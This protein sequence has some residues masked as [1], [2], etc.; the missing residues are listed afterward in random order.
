MP[1]WV[2]NKVSFTGG[3]AVLMKLRNFMKTENS[4]FDF[5]K[6]IP[7]PESLNISDGSE[8]TIARACAMARRRG[9]TTCPEVE[10]EWAKSRSFDEWAD[11]GEIY[12]KNI[13]KYG[14]PTWYDWRCTHWGTKWNAHEPWWSDDNTELQ[15]ETAWSMPEP[16]FAELSRRYPGIKIHIDFADEDLGNNCGTW[17]LPDEDAPMYDG[18]LEFA[19]NVWDYDYEEILKEREEYDADTEQGSQW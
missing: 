2:M 4:E 10:K 19:C 17:D 12:L 6:L 14:A 18:D 5:E 15:F 9:E 8:E 16:V 3:K 7:M 11:Y 13:E 1:N